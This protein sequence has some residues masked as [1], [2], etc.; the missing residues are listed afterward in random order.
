MKTFPEAMEVVCY[1]FD[2]SPDQFAKAKAHDD[3]LRS[4]I[5]SLA[6]E[7]SEHELT[8]EMVQC[9]MHDVRTGR[10]TPETAVLNA[11]I[12]GVVVGMEMEKQL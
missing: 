9:C 1:K 4:R 7:I 2:A 11:F 10:V 12:N 5:G 6:E 8:M 3:D